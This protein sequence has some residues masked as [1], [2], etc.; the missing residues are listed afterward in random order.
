M[1]IRCAASAPGRNRLGA[2][3]LL[4]LALFAAGCGGLGDAPA[5]RLPDRPAGAVGAEALARQISG[6]PLAAREER[7]LAEV[8]SGNV[9]S[10]IRQLHPVEVR[11]E[12][13]GRE[14]RIT[15]WVTPDYL[16]VGSD[17]DFMLVPLSSGAAARVAERLGALLPTPK[18]VDAIWA[19][20]DFRLSPI[21]LAADEAMRNVSYFRNHDRLV[22][23]QRL[24]YDTSPGRFVAGHKVDVVLT[25][26]IANGSARS[27]IYG[28]HRLNGR[29]I[30]PLYTSAEP[31][32]IF[33][34]GVRL[35]HREAHVDGVETDLL[36]V[37][38]DP[39]LSA[40]LSDQ[41]AIPL[42]D[43]P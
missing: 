35:V 2:V 20:A 12:V 8:V 29:P 21:R 41:G 22:K 24:I 34:H 5:L 38:R 31:F 1:K 39:S 28:W 15:S 30:Q 16:A 3:G 27:A 7:I 19:T 9:P 37:L 23:S 33:S 11:S 42:T 4:Q 10:W 6:L 13:D 18:L 36:D 40:I 32:V 26:D 14:R 17:D 43:R 25:P